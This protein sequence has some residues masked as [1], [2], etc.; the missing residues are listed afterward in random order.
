M[1]SFSASAKAFF[2]FA[3]PRTLCLHGGFDFDPLIV[4]LI[5]AGDTIATGTVECRGGLGRT[6]SE[7]TRCLLQLHYRIQ[8][9][10]RAPADRG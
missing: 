3:C 1:R 8:I 4:D 5:A 7:D 6:P 10:Y 2:A 9:S